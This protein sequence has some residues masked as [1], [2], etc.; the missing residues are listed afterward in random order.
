MFDL[1]AKISIGSR[2]FYS[3]ALEAKTVSFFDKLVKKGIVNTV[4]KKIHEKFGPRVWDVSEFLSTVSDK[5]LKSNAIP[6]LNSRM[7]QA[8]ERKFKTGGFGTWSQIALNTI[9]RRERIKSEGEPTEGRTD[10]PLWFSGRLSLAAQKGFQVTDFNA[11]SKDNVS[12]NGKDVS[13]ISTVSPIDMS[14]AY[15][16]PKGMWAKTPSW[17]KRKSTLH[18]FEE[19]IAVQSFG[20]TK[21]RIPARNIPLWVMLRSKERF[22]EM[23]GSKEFNREVWSPFLKRDFEKI[24][25]KLR[26]RKSGNVRIDFEDKITAVSKPI[27]SEFEVS[28]SDYRK[29]LRK[30]GKPAKDIE[31]AISARKKWMEEYL[32]GM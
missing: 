31:A 22:G 30:Q 24:F 5:D 19:L 27:F 10:T 29:A 28:E 3:G 26:K 11:F 4:G 25:Q 16:E 17:Y 9:N 8:Y 21:S 14:V 15:V 13:I 18:S 20:G 32:K 1:T 7:E 23:G 6:L 12:V 2:V